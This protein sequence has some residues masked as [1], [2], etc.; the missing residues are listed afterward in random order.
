M[1]AFEIAFSILV[2]KKHAIT[3]KLFHKV[4]LHE[5]QQEKKQ[6]ILNVIIWEPWGFKSLNCFELWNVGGTNIWAMGISNKQN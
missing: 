5:I 6:F 3:E 2:D 4:M 1:A